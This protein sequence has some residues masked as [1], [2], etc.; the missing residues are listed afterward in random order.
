MFA[1][2][3]SVCSSSFISSN[4]H[5][6][7]GVTGASLWR[8]RFLNLLRRL[9]N[10]ERD[11]LGYVV[12]TFATRGPSSVNSSVDFSCESSV[13]LFIGLV[14][15]SS[16]NSSFDTL[17]FLLLPDAQAR[18]CSMASPKSSGTSSPVEQKTPERTSVGSTNPASIAKILSA[19]QESMSTMKW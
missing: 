13:I 8:T 4:T 18:A 19:I 16:V 1:D 10:V 11:P 6:T 12:P 2:A 15:D 7:G 9:L 3:S 14:R 17:R 5:H